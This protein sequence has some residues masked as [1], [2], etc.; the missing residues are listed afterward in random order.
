[1]EQRWAPA[2]DGGAVLAKQLPVVSVQPR[3][4]QSLGSPRS[5]HQLGLHVLMVDYA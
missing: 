3:S 5:F 2:S 1:M 4:H